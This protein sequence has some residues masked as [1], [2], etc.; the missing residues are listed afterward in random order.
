MSVPHA[1]LS[2]VASIVREGVDPR[3]VAN[4]TRYVG[5]EHISSDG[6]FSGAANI[7]ATELASTKFAFGDRHILFGKLRP[8][9]RKVL[10]PTFAGICST[11]IIPIAPG[12]DLDRDYLFHFLRTDQVIER[13]TSMASGANLPRISPKHLIEFEIPLP[14]LD[15]QRR[16]ATILDQADALRRCRRETLRKVEALQLSQFETMFGDPRQNP[17]GWATVPFGHLLTDIQSG[18]SPTCLDRP[19]EEDEWGVLKLGAVTYGRFDDTAQKALPEGTPPRPHIEVHVGDLLF[20]RKNTHELVAA[21]A[22]VRE[23]RPRL[24]LSDL[25]FRLCLADPLRSHPEYIHGLLSHP[26][27]RAEIQNLASGAAGS[28]PNI[29][30]ARLR[31]VPISLPPPELQARFAEFVEELESLRSRAVD[32]LGYLDSLFASLQHRA[33]RGEL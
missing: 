7:E 22:L 16:I 5:L 17:R 8:Y 21:C 33:F 12:P 11:D 2:S 10:R 23:T 24:L 26:A 27:K 15:E 25:I 19:A 28:M 18:W 6:D 14:S 31:T 9:L 20:T 4:G 32:H 30:K 3:R 29:S 1:R 13:A